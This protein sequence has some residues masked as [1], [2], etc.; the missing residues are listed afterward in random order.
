MRRLKFVSKLAF[1]E[2]VQ[3]LETVSPAQ[4]ADELGITY[5][6]AARRLYRYNNTGLME[7]LGIEKGRWCLSGKGELQLDYLR[8]M[9][10]AGL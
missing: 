4:L 10:E 8:K 9:K 3:R 2:L 5:T 6:A 7:P 1:L